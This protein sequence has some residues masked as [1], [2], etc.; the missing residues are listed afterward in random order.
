MVITKLEF[1]KN[2]PNR[3]NVFIDGTFAVGVTTE[4]VLKLGLK[5]DQ[6]ISRDFLKKIVAESDFGKLFNRIVNFIS[7]RPRSEWEIRHKFYQEKYLIE[8]VEKLKQM[9]LVNDQNFAQ[10]FLEQRKVFRPKG[11][12]AIKSELTRLGVD[13]NIIDNAL[14]NSPVDEVSQARKLLI[15]KFKTNFDLLRAQRFLL[16]R[17]FSWNTIKTTLA[18]KGIEEL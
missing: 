17:G 4:A 3:V 9:G 8:V 7:F 11:Q 16:S 15:K 18:K 14:R 5:K 6:E 10:W 2:D 1:Q 13:R 12:L